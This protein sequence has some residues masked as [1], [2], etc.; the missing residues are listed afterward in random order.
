[1]ADSAKTLRITRIHLSGLRGLH[2]GTCD[3]LRGFTSNG[4]PAA[5]YAD[6][7][8]TDYADYLHYAD[9]A[10]YG[11]DSPRTDYADYVS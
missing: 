8:R 3:G 11:T 10:D 2:T 7:P 5:D 1:M 4:L 6:S 9:Y